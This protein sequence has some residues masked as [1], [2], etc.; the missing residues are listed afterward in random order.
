MGNL[1]KNCKIQ[2]NTAELI[3]E[4]GSLFV[5]IFENNIVHVAQKPGIESVAIEEGFIP[6]AATPDVTCKDTSD[7]KGTAAEAGVSDAAVKAVISA[8]DITVNVKDNEKLD[9][10]YKGKL[11][12][13]DYEKARKKS[14]K[15]PYEDLAIAELEGHTVGKDEEKTDSVTIIKKLGKDDAVYGLGDKPGCLNKRGYSYVNWNT[16]DP[17]PHVDSFK[18]LYKSIPFFIVLGDEYC[19][20][21][22]AD[23]TYKTT[24]DFGYE[25]TDYY[26]VEHEKGELDYYFM[27]GNDM[28]EVVGLYTSLTGT[29]P[30]YQRWIYGSHQSRWG[31]YTQ[32]EVLDIADKFR[33]LDIPC[34]VIHMDIDYMNG[35]RVF[36]F[37][38]KKFPDV[39]G[40]S[41][42]LA[43][44]GVKLISIIDPGVKKDEDY[45]MY[46]EGMEMDAFAHDTD[47]SVYENA[48]WPGTSVFPDF[49]KQ[50]VRSWW[51]DKTKILL[52]HGISGI[53][54]DMNEPASFNGP[55]PDDVQFEYGAHEKVHNIYGHFMAKATYEGLAKND[56]G[57][58]PFVLTRAAYAG[59]QKYC[60][61]WTGDNHSIW[62]HIA[63]SLEQVCNLSVSGLA[64]CGSDIGGFGSD[65]TPEL[66]VRF[67]EAAV[68]VPFFR[69]HSAM[70][71]RRQE[72]WQFDETTI[73]AVRKT[74]KL[75]YRFI[76]YIYDLAHECEKTGAP[77]VRSL[78]YEYP[79][80]KHVRN[81][82]DEYMLGSFVLVAPVIAPGKEAREVYLPDGD[83]YDYYTG[84]KYSGGRYIL[85]D[86]P[87][88]KVP[89]F[90]KAGAIIPVA[91][92]EIRSTEDITE[93]KIS[94]LTYPGKGSFVHYQDDNETFAYR[95]GEYNAVEYTLDGDKLE[96][97]VLHKGL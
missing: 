36:T 80:D 86:A 50:S 52:E 30:L 2:D 97:K 67:Y 33:E 39:K 44:R 93:D 63:L 75:R 18:S 82:S 71:T 29:T 90:I 12:L 17:A 27:P 13:S 72:P 8:R 48:V 65:T 37:D 32:D 14:E 10:Y 53:W 41:E 84:E 7:A 6:K 77:I 94:I 91:D 55:L 59:S 88:D 11:V 47:G 95:N 66:L 20:G 4:K 92:G 15:N 19:Y 38:D 46:K 24:F 81:I 83:W 16:D 45:F 26:F 23:N 85:A 96:K 70:G 35:Y 58:R 69:N 40:L 68:F 22:F 21:I 51:G 56:G 73:D 60:G 1:Y 79:A 5:T 49:T 3:Y 62:A 64:M 43:D 25:N 31:Y 61:G 54:N 78:V 74:V 9:I 87:L 89:V 57:K 76:P 42:K 28:A 34:D